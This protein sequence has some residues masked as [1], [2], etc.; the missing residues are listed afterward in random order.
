MEYIEDISELIRKSASGNSDCFRQLYEHLVDK[1]FAYVRYRTNSEDNA[2]DLTQEVFVDIYKALPGFTYSSTEQFYGFVFTITK[3]KLAKYYADKHTQAAKT[4]S[5][6]NEDNYS[7][8][9]LELEV[10]R[11]VARALDTLDDTTR[12]IVVLHHWSRYT[13]PEI[14]TLI[15]MTESAVRVRHHRALKLLS[16]SLHS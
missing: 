2:I 10:S 12:E 16:A 15:H 8:S 3:R 4:T 7:E 6:F 5:E 1:V 11:D 9:S 14:A 13:F